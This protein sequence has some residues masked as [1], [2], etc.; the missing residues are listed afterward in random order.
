MIEKATL[1]FLKDLARH[2]D[3]AWF[4]ANRDRYR[5]AAAN[6]RDAAMLL[7]ARIERF[8]PSV[9]GV[10]P[11]E[12]LFRIYR[13]TR[14]SRDKTP[15][16]THIGIF[17]KRGG[18]S[19]T[20]A[21]YYLHLEP[22]ACM[23]GGGIYLPAAPELKAIRAAIVDRTAE[24]RKILNAKP[25]VAEFGELDDLRLKTAPKGYAKDHPA[26]ELLRYT[27]FT[28]TAGLPDRRVL[29]ADFPDECARVFKL[30]KPLNDFI[31]GAIF[32]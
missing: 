31:N 5:A 15:Y 7:L 8:D 19:T 25:F 16:K 28:V 27:S 23:Y 11:D 22:G 24:F 4:D 21:G 18:R 1:D 29:S 3:R 13:D 12:C 26:I 20:G 30:M 10:G 14:F 17:M 32:S 2:N 9:V 6:V